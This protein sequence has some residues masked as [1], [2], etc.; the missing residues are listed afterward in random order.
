MGGSD[1]SEEICAGDKE[2]N[3]IREAMKKGGTGIIQK[4]RST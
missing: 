2:E 3:M 1:C 4:S